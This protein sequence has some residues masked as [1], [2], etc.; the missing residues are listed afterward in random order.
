MGRE[1]GR[2]YF[3][4]TGLNAGWVKGPEHEFRRPSVERGRLEGGE[5]C[6]LL[7]ESALHDR[8][9]GGSDEKGNPQ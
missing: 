9:T 4:E 6:L 5:L 7:N 2:P 3:I 8:K 1:A